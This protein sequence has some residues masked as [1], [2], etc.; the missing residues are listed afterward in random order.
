M[1]IHALESYLWSSLELRISEICH[2][3]VPV[4]GDFPEGR[5]NAKEMAEK[6]TSIPGASR[7][8]SALRD[9]GYDLDS[10]VADIVDNS[11]SR[12]KALN[13]YIDFGKDQ[14]GR[15]RLLVIDD[16]QGMDSETLEEAMRIGS[17]NIDYAK[18][19]LRKYGMGMKTASMS[20]ASVITVLSR[21]EGQHQTAYRWDLNHVNRTDRWE[22][23]RLSAGDIRLIKES[24]ASVEKCDLETLFERVSWTVV[25]W[26]N[27]VKFQKD[28]DSYGSSV[29]AQNY[30]FRILDRL[31]TYLRLVFHRFLSGENSARKTNLY[32]NGI[33]L[34]PLDPFCRNEEHTFELRLSERNGNFIID[35]G[36]SP[37]VIRRYVLPTNPKK[38]GSYRFSSVKAWEEAAGTKSWNESQG[39]Y[40]YR[41]NRLVNWGGW[42]R[43]KAIDEHDKLARA[44]I[45]LT[46]EHDELF[47]IDVK[48]T[49][50]QFPEE[51]RNHLKDNVNAKFIAEAK[52]RYAGSERRNVEVVNAVREQSRKVSHLASEL[53]REDDISVTE[54]RKEGELVIKNR[55]GRKVS[56]DQTYRM[57]DAG[58]RI[59]SAPFGDSV[60]FWKMVPSPYNEFQVM[61]NTEHPFYKVV[62]GEA[63]SDSK[64][65]AIM[66]AFLFTMSFIELKC[67]T[68]G[69][70]VLF[71]QM[72][73]VASS[74][75]EKFVKDEIIKS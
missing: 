15:F 19:D 37:I 42:Y 57:L 16:G 67:I 20:Q 73:E 70:E 39:Y 10:A 17:G 40:V 50:I 11:I 54:G 21:R 8:V 68:N 71:D 43:T 22:I 58:K 1:Y 53:V 29:S 47:T 9:F 5:K 25:I 65:T 69:N 55:F 13:V 7:T 32:V 27:L 48:K 60:L 24:L 30:F 18:G 3:L 28:H 44:S 62:Y 33:K 23:F 74:V 61:V 14:N 41:N 46:D 59:I 38:P 4:I 52:R 34:E 56:E 63:N 51:L 6:I 12:G 31:A 26:E 64:T 2:P 36:M 72:K 35:K 66:D 45:D 75:L 49:R